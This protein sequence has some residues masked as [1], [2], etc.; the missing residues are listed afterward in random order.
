MNS[1]E[2]Y[3]KID[4]Q[5]HDRVYELLQILEQDM[6]FGELEEQQQAAQE[7]LEDLVERSKN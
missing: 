3:A 5:Y 4:S 6:D 2:Y 7:E 1:L